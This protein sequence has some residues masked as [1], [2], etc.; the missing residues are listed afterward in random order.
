LSSHLSLLSVPGRRSPVP[1]Q[2]VGELRLSRSLRPPCA[3]QARAWF[4]AGP[5]PVG[6]AGRDEDKAVS[7]I[8]SSPPEEAEPWLLS[9]AGVGAV[10]GQSAGPRARRRGCATDA[11]RWR[12][13]AQSSPGEDAQK[14]PA[15][16][17]GAATRSRGR[18][19]ADRLLAA[20]DVGPSPEAAPRAAVSRRAPL[21]PKVPRRRRPGGCRRQ[22]EGDGRGVA[23]VVPLSPGMAVGVGGAA[24]VDVGEASKGL[25]ASDAPSR[26]CR[27]R[28]TACRG[29][30]RS[31][32]RDLLRS[33]G[34]GASRLA[35]RD[36]ERRLWRQRRDR[37][38]RQGAPA[39]PGS[40]TRPP[41]A[42]RPRYRR[43]CCPPRPSWSASPRRR[44]PG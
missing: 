7:N 39:E 3:Q 21:R 36:R 18:R 41:P 33:M 32:A 8:P 11:A 30:R 19:E 10:A 9:L 23:L 17:R 24:S 29:D 26:P 35:R 28:Q 1:A 27:P 43:S 14:S 37:R 15:G 16:R 34:P 2:G 38:E 44:H 5:K 6:E 42:A 12:R 25:G 20:A 4:G 13:K 22:Q 40:P 31:F